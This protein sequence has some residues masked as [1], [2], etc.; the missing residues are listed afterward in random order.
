[1]LFYANRVIELNVTNNADKLIMALA[2]SPGKVWLSSIKEFRNLTAQYPDKIYLIQANNMYAFF[3]SMEN[4][5]NIR[6]DF[7][8]MRLPVVK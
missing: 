5:K 8:A 6:Y 7:S 4:R 1:M 2:S 3:T